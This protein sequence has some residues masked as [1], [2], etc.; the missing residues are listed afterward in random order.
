M[1][2]PRP[3]TDQQITAARVLY[4]AGEVALTDIAKHTGIHYMR[5]IALADKCGWVRQSSVEEITRAR[6]IAGN[7]YQRRALDYLCSLIPTGDPSRD[8]EIVIE[9][10]RMALI[11]GRRAT[12]SARAALRASESF[13]PARSSRAG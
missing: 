2:R 8:D 11:L 10:R 3:L 9:T 4:E 1:S 6:R 5:L 7:G 12:E 13:H